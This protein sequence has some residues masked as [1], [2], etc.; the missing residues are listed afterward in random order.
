[1]PTTS[2]FGCEGGDLTV[3]QMQPIGGP[4]RCGG[5]RRILVFAR[6]GVRS[7]E[8]SRRHQFGVRQL[9]TTSISGQEGDDRLVGSEIGDDLLGGGASTRS[10]VNGVRIT[11]FPGPVG[12]R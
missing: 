12:A 2:P 11:W 10:R 1:M 9:A 5:L 6:R 4:T 8:P 3:N 7:G